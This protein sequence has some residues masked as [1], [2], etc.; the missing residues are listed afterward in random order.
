MGSLFC[1]DYL[2]DIRFY[3]IKI[4]PFV[5]VLGKHELLMELDYKAQLIVDWR[6]DIDS[7]FGGS[8]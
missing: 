8:I 5:S 2:K 3:L 6:D 4:G 7:I 1:G